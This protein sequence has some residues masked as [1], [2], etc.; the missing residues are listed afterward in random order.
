[1]AKPYERHK[2]LSWEKSAKQ[3]IQE[4]PVTVEDSVSSVVFNLHCTLK[5]FGE[6]KKSPDALVSQS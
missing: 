1:M 4:I 5:S 3:A 6:L 2:S